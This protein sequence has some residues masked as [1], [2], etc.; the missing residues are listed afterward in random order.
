MFSVPELM[1]LSTVRPNPRDITQPGGIRTV[2]RYSVSAIVIAWD[3]NERVSSV[4]FS[5]Q[6]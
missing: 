1:Q 2:L 5:N 3:V 6:V 4:P